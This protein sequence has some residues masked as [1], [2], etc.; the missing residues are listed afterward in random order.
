MLTKHYPEVKRK[1]KKPLA[2]HKSNIFYLTII[3]R[4]EERK[5]PV[6]KVIALNALS[7]VLHNS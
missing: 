2:S 1:Y 5:K 3:Y 6:S 4:T 7:A